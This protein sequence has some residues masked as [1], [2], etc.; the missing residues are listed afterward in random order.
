M[1]IFL[2][3]KKEY[4]FN[5]KEYLKRKRPE[6]K[7]LKKIFGASEFKMI[8]IDSL[9][10]SIFQ[11]YFALSNSFSKNKFFKILGLKF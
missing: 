2:F 10:L 1:S 9:F 5:I 3:L 8:L 7:D 6:K 4:I 11:K